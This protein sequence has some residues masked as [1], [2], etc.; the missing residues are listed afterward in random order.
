MKIVTPRE[1]STATRAQRGQ[2]RAEGRKALSST[3]EIKD[4]R[5]LLPQVCIIAYSHIFVESLFLF[6]CHLPYTSHSHT[7]EE[8]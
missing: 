6:C 3:F 2:A 5:T 7:G 1:V 4:R 8:A